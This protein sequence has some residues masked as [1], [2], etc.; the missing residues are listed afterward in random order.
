MSTLKAMVLAAGLGTR[1]RPLTDTIPKPLIPVSGEPL[2]DRVLN[3]LATGGIHEVVV[4][5][6][7][8]AQLLEAHL[9]G[10]LQKRPNA[11]YITTVRE[12]APLETGGGIKHA[13]PWLGDAVFLCANS[14]T[15][16]VNG[17]THA[18]S[19]LQ[20][21]WDDQRMDALLL[22]HPVEQAI[23]YDGK[24]DFF[25]NTDGTL[26]RRG[27]AATAP[28]VFTGVQLLH[29]RLF[30]GAP[31]GVFSMN[32]LYNKHQKPD[33]TLPRIY[34]LVHDGHW[35][36]VGDPAGLA[37]AEKWLTSQK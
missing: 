2:I 27:E 13:M 14:D 23:G 37:L 29:P 35:L 4:N 26:R 5:S 7:Y 25:L 33:G 1:M 24:G 18:T 11:P 15:I 22:L 16:C 8:K 20:A 30:A 9:T 36:H 21:Q 28:Y 17:P 3:W 19:R 31:E 12:E 6:S 10:R 34:G 32:V